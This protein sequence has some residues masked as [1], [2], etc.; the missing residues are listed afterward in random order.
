M[1]NWG[2]IFVKNI[3]TYIFFHF[4]LSSTD[5]Y[6]CNVT[7]RGLNTL[8]RHCMYFVF[9]L[10]GTHRHSQITTKS[11]NF[12]TFSSCCLVLLLVRALKDKVS[13]T[14]GCKTFLNLIQQ[15][16]IKSELWWCF[17]RCWKRNKKPSETVP[18][19]Q[20]VTEF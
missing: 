1:S 9:T 20:H 8:A 13:L 19:P 3:E 12:A 4:T 11:D 16:N 14:G 18:A 10:T 2:F 17:K 6:G 7:S 15:P 5:V